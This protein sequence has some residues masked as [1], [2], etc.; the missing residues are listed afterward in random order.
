MKVNIFLHTILHIKVKFEQYLHCK[1]LN[2]IW[3]AAGHDTSWYVQ[4]GVLLDSLEH[5]GFDRFCDRRLRHFLLVLTNLIDSLLLHDY[6]HY[7]HYTGWSGLSRIFCEHENLSDLSVIQL[8][9]IK[10]YRQIGKNLAKNLGLAG[11]KL[12]CCM[13]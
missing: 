11:I 2:H 1:S 10:L 13:V 3:N 7:I 9:Y 4:N 12:N 8:I 6:I 5:S